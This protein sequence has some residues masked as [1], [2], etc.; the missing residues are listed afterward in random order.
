MLREL[1]T[2]GNWLFILIKKQRIRSSS[3]SYSIMPNLR[4]RKAR[5]CSTNFTS[6]RLSMM[7]NVRA[8]WDHDQ[9]LKAPI[10]TI[11]NISRTAAVLCTTSLSCDHQI[12]QYWII[13]QQPLSSNT[14]LLPC[15]KI[16]DMMK[17]I[18]SFRSSNS[19][20]LTPQPT[21]VSLILTFSSWISQ[22]LLR[23]E[24]PTSSAHLRSKALPI[25]N[26]L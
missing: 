19:I 26:S 11:T 21:L 10:A 25:N 23:Q 5:Q 9:D 1:L 4:F 8:R 18:I 24:C 2:I 17:A 3:S 22:G 12:N 7:K 13:C 16:R 6:R 15:I 20:L 14:L